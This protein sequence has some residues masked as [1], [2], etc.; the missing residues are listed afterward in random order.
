LRQHIQRPWRTGSLCQVAGLQ[1][2]FVDLGFFRCPQAVGD[3]DD[4]DPVDQRLVVLVVAEAL[5][6]G[7]VGVREDHALV[8][9]GAD[10]LGADVVAFLGRGEQRVQDLDRRLEHLD[11]LEKALRRQVQAA[12]VAIGV[13]V[14]L[15]VE[16]ELA[17]VDLADQGRDILVVVIARLGL[18][19]ADLVQLRGHEASDGEL[20]YVAVELR[21]PLQRPR[22]HDAGEIPFRNPVALGQQGAEALRIEQAQGRFED[23]ADL[24]AG[25]QHIDRQLLHERLEPLGQGRLAAAD[26]TQQVED[27][28]A[29]LQALR[30]VLEEPDDPLDRLFHPIEV[31]EAG[32]ALDRAVHEDP[33]ESRIAGGVDDLRLA[34]RRD[35]PLGGVGVRRRALATEVQVVPKREFGLF[36]AVEERRV[37][38]KNV[39]MLVHPLPRLPAK[40]GGNSNTALGCSGSDD[41]GSLTGL[42]VKI[43]NNVP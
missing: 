19:H 25:L 36:S 20:R 27:L 39:K 23:R 22:G 43:C 41:V 7:L 29:L 40:N 18:G 15:A 21:H 9:D 38:I 10:A 3:V 2:L 31:G 14:V 26:R 37:Q 17:D 8:G 28:L 5:P 1:E 12:A 4:A 30:G 24:V 35:H 42:F 6:L 32:V 34:D 11:E 13:G 33:A 16:F